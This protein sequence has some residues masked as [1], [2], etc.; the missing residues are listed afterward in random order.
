MK[1]ALD[2]AHA[3]VREFPDEG[4]KIALERVL[5]LVDVLVSELGGE[6]G[7]DASDGQP[8]ARL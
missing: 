7:A 1:L 4:F 8:F 3:H 5:E 2:H 6:I